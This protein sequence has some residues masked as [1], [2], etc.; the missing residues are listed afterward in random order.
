M[1]IIIISVLT[2]SVSNRQW[3]HNA[4]SKLSKYGLKRAA[5]ASSSVLYKA[6]DRRYQKLNVTSATCKKVSEEFHPE[7]IV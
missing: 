4:S 2:A 3:T 6:S 5:F 7:N 1:L